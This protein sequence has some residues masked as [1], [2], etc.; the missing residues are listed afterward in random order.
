[1]K[2]LLLAASLLGASGVVFGALGA[3]G[4]EGTTEALA[5]WHTG[6]TYQLLHAVA[7]LG[8]VATLRGRLACLA[9]WGF[10]VGTVLFSGALYLPPL[11]GE[12]ALTRVAPW[13]GTLLIVAWVLVGVSALVGG[14]R[15]G[16]QSD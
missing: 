7:V 2:L 15:V 12:T 11:V 9:A 1:M 13:G 16:A 10:V 14:R 5:N 3:H 6:V 8:V 4:V